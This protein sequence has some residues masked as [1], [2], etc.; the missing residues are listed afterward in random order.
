VLAGGS[1]IA[2]PTPKRNTPDLITTFFEAAAV[3]VEN[4]LQL[5]GAN[6]RSDVRRKYFSTSIFRPWVIEKD[7][8]P[9]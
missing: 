4:S 5:S 8:R 9:C 3:P 7:Q 1:F 6:R 2:I